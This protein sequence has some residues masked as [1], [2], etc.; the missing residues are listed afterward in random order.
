MQQA[1]MP[2]HEKFKI[3][4]MLTF[5][6]GFLDAY[7][8][9]LRGGVFANAQTGN[10]VLFSVNFARG[11]WVDSTYFLIP[12]FAFGSG[13]FVT[14]VLSKKF[15]N[16]HFWNFER[17]ILSSEIIILLIVGF[18]PLSLPH[19][20]VNVTVSF[21]CSIQFNAFRKVRNMPY[22]SIMC[23]GNLRSGID[24]LLFYFNKK[25]RSA[26]KN[27]FHYFGIISFFILGAIAG[28]IFT[29]L[30]STYSIWFCCLLLFIVLY[31]IPAKQ[32]V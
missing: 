12:I 23:T 9:I 17:I 20:I 3:A 21:V 5:V 4:A 29:K 31:M 6:G 14:N 25:D 18:L 15:S 10:M 30:L 1:E 22:A 11:N 16:K 24:K 7:T 19:G 13:V 2:S 26:L 28:T 27:A 32:K 8:Y